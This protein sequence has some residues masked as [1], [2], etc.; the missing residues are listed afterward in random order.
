MKKSRESIIRKGNKALIFA[1]TK[2]YQLKM[3]NSV[4]PKTKIDSK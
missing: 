1:Q 3:M 2:G 4:E